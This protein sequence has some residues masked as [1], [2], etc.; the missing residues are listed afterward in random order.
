MTRKCKAAIA[1]FVLQFMFTAPPT[2]A[3]ADMIYTYTGRLFTIIGDSTTPAG[4]YTTSMS[5]S[6]SFT[7]ANPLAAN[8]VNSDIA[9]SV[10]DFSFFDGRTTLSPGNAARKTFVFSTDGA[11]DIILWDVVAST[12]PP[13]TV[14]QQFLQIET[15][16][17]PARFRDFDRGLIGVC[18]SLP[19]A[20][21]FGD[22]AQ[23]VEMPGTWSVSEISSVPGPIA[24]AGLPGL[25]MAFGGLLAWRRRKAVAA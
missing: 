1:I 20:T 2:P 7:V 3:N 14:G 22:T 10:L 24:G 18:S 5:V 16:E 13:D 4:T 9:G 6:G 8:L 19:C 15:H 21:L 11:G 23:N 25:V 12:Q 17:D